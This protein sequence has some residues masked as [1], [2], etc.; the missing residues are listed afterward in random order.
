MLTSISPELLRVGEVCIDLSKK[1]EAAQ[2]EDG[3]PPFEVNH[4]ERLLLLHCFHSLKEIV[5]STTLPK[6]RVKAG[7]TSREEAIAEVAD[8]DRLL[9]D[10]D[11]GRF[12]S[13]KQGEAMAKDARDLCKSF[14]IEVPFRCR[15]DGGK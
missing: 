8:I 9:S 14:D 10:G 15:A 5:D 4:D 7:P 6:D 3:D 12:Y 1:I 2:V 13:R 11:F